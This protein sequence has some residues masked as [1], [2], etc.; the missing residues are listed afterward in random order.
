MGQKIHFILLFHSRH[1]HKALMSSQRWGLTVLGCGHWDCFFSFSVLCVSKA[2]EYLKSGWEA[3][4]QHL[5]QS[6]HVAHSLLQ[7]CRGS[8]KVMRCTNIPSLHELS[9]CVHDATK[10][11]HHTENKQKWHVAS[12]D[13]ITKLLLFLFF[14]L[15]LLS[16]R[17]KRNPWMQDDSFP[18]DQPVLD[19]RWID[20]LSFYGVCA[21]PRL[22]FIFSSLLERWLLFDSSSST[23]SSADRNYRIERRQNVWRLKPVRTLKLL[24]FLCEKL[25]LSL[26]FPFLRLQLVLHLLCV[27]CCRLVSHHLTFKSGHLRTKK[28]EIALLSEDVFIFLGSLWNNYSCQLYVLFQSSDFLFRL[29]KFELQVTYLSV[30]VSWKIFR[31]GKY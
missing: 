25:Y 24:F 2:G 26:H 28:K 22:D 8:T 7:Q 5:L 4:V 23:L 12:V 21:M 29:H 17:W 30:R 6:L 27:L 19:K 15:Q 1:T 9:G 13:I 14:F 20:L 16:G 3:A 18:S 31:K 10:I 11:S